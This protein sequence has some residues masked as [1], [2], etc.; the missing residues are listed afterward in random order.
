MVDGVQICAWGMPGPAQINSMRSH[1]PAMSDRSWFPQA[2]RSYPDFQ[3]RYASTDAK[4]ALLFNPPPPPPPPPPPHPPG[5]PPP[6]SGAYAPQHG[7]CRDR[8]GDFTSPRLEHYSISFAACKAKCDA[9]RSR[10]DAF[11]ING[12]VPAGN[13]SLP[14]DAWCGVWGVGLTRKDAVTGFTFFCDGDC[15]KGQAT[16]VCRG[17]PAAGETNTCFPKA[18]AC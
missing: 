3:K 2:L 15:G 6:P 11:D 5:P 7:A 10:C 12:A 9:L 8:G 16:P 1:A 4:L 18:P 13:A 14:V 17:D